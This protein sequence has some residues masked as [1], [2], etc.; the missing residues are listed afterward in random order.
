MAIVNLVNSILTVSMAFV[1]FGGG[2]MAIQFS[3][4]HWLSFISFFAFWVISSIEQ[5]FF[6]FNVHMSCYPKKKLKY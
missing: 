4:F 6:F 2:D 3:L 1:F 5:A